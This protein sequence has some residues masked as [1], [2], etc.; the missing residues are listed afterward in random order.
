MVTKNI[1]GS[2][3]DVK[4]VLW[5]LYIFVLLNIL[6]SD[7]ISLLDLKRLFIFYLWIK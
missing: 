4:E 6:Y 1:I 2:N 7:M 3:T 5:T